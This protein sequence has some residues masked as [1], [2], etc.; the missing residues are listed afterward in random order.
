[1]PQWIIKCPNY[2]IEQ[3]LV[4][5]APGTGVAGVPSCSSGVVLPQSAVKQVEPHSVPVPISEH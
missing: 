1:M 2:I 4:T 3:I 5:A